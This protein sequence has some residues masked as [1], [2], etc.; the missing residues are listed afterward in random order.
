MIGSY[1]R[2]H[3]NGLAGPPM[4]SPLCMALAAPRTPAMPARTSLPCTR[5]SSAVC[6]QRGNFH[7]SSTFLSQWTPSLSNAFDWSAS[8]TAG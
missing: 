7:A 6:S 5:D 4:P 3:R 8:S 2:H 1:A